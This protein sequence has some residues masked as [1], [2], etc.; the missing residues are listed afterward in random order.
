MFRI[1]PGPLHDRFYAARIAFIFMLQFLKPLDSGLRL[2]H[3]LLRFLLCL[4]GLLLLL[5][6]STDLIR[7]LQDLLALGLILFL[8]LLQ[9]LLLGLCVFS[10][11]GQLLLQSLQAL[12]NISL[13]PLFL[14]LTHFLSGRR[15]PQ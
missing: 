9:Q 6:D 1:H 15:I 7:K 12:L 14:F 8:R 5:A 2:T 11:A 3:L 10:A 4:H 13:L